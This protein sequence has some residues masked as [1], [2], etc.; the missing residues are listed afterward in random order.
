MHS[1]SSARNN[2]YLQPVLYNFLEA[3]IPLFC[4]QVVAENKCI[5]V[6]ECVLKAI[7]FKKKH[8]LY[9]NQP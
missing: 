6:G 9:L 2:L 5:L 4:T 7:S 8:M 3:I 1:S